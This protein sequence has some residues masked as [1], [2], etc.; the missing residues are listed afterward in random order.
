MIRERFLNFR[1]WLIPYF[2]WFLSF[3][4]SNAPRKYRNSNCCWQLMRRYIP[5]TLYIMRFSH[6]PIHSLFVPWSPL[7]SPDANVASLLRVQLAARDVTKVYEKTK[8]RRNRSS[9]SFFLSTKPALHE[10]E[11][12][13]RDVCAASCSAG[14]RHVRAIPVRSR[15]YFFPSHLFSLQQIC[16]MKVAAFFSYILLSYLIIYFR[17]HSL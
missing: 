10:E 11:T 12:R 8:E 6:S 4:L 2:D 9:L 1:L 16:Q 7:L 15:R 17:R 3:C 5:D 14:W 13:T